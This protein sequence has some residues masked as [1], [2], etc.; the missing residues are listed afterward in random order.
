MRAVSGLFDLHEAA[1]KHI[2]EKRPELLPM[3]SAW[4][5]LL[6]A[7]EE[8][9]MIEILKAKDPSLSAVAAFAFAMVR[10]DFPENHPLL[11][12][13]WDIET[14]DEIGWCITEALGG[15]DT[16]WLRDRVILPW[17]GSEAE[18]NDLLCYLVQ[19]SALAPEGSPQRKYLDRCLRSP[20]VAARAVHAMAECCASAEERESLRGLCEKI[21]MKEWQ[22]VYKLA[23]IPKPD[24]RDGTVW[25]LQHAALEALR[26]VGNSATVDLLRQ[27]RTKLPNILAQLSFEVGEEI[28]WRC[29]EDIASGTGG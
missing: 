24:H 23:G 29:T 9:P 13:F 16:A 7:G 4:R 3:I 27:I 12:T 18:P 22:A 11:E 15:M 19:K 8:A 14:P 25:K 10:A 2:R 5:G 17:I 28:Y 21:L 6:T 20:K 26:N 1:E